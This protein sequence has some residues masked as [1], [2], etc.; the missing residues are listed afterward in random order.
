MAENLQAAFYQIAE[1]QR[2]VKAQAEHIASIDRRNDERDQ[3][4]SALERKQLL[5]GITFLGGIIITLGGVIWSYR[6]VIFKG[7]S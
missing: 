4:R 6:G 7:Q 2:T 3:E 1:L 5:W